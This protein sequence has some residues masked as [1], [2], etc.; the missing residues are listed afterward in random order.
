MKLD[1]EFR[2]LIPS[3]T[4][5]EKYQLQESILKEGCRDALVLWKGILIDGHNRHEICRKNKIP[6]KTVSLNLDT[7]AEVK[8]WI[9][10]NQLGRR[11]LTTE[12]RNY[13][14]GKLYSATKQPH[15]GNRKNG[16][17]KSSSPQN[18]DL[19]KTS[20]KI[21][22]QIK[23]GKATVERAEK[24]AQA[25]D[26]LSE[27][28]GEAIKNRILTRD[29]RATQEEILELANLSEKQQKSVLRVVKEKDYPLKDALKEIRDLT[30]YRKREFEVDAALQSLKDNMPS[31]IQI[32]SED[33][34]KR[35]DKFGNMNVSYLSYNQYNT[36]KMSEETY[37]RIKDDVRNRGF[38]DPIIYHC[39]DGEIISG[40]HRVKIARELGKE[41]ELKLK[42]I[43][44]PPLNERVMLAEMFNSRGFPDELK[45]AEIY[46]LLV[47]K[48]VTEGL[49]IEKAKER[50]AVESTYS[51]GMIG[52]YYFIGERI[53]KDHPWFPKEIDGIAVSYLHA[54]YL[55][56]MD[57]TRK[58]Y[59]REM[60]VEEQEHVIRKIIGWLRDEYK[61]NGR[62]VSADRLQ[63]KIR[64]TLITDFGKH[65]PNLTDVPWASVWYP[66]KRVESI[67]H[68]IEEEAELGTYRR[69]WKFSMNRLTRVSAFPMSVAFNLLRLLSREL[70]DGG[71]VREQTFK[72]WV[73]VDPFCGYGIR[74]VAARY[75]GHTAYGYDVSP[76]IM[77]KVKELWSEFADSF[78]VGDSRYLPHED[79]SVDLIFTSPPYW[80]VEKYEESEDNV[81]PEFKKDK[82]KVQSQ[83]SRIN[84]YH[85]FLSELFQVIAE[86]KRVVKVGGYLVIVVANF[87]E[88]G[89]YYPFV[90]AVEQYI[91]DNKFEYFDKLI[92]AHDISKPTGGIKSIEK[93]HTRVAHEEMLIFK[94]GNK[95]S[96]EKVQKQ[97]QRPRSLYLSTP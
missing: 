36:N 68:F 93:N 32:Y 80:R 33:K 60:G 61:V 12:A 70:T 43:G 86:M 54:Y 67:R 79:E 28:H 24:Y 52:R 47:Q 2:A 45:K 38:L 88:K 26:K 95:L 7:R 69:D 39:S 1:S 91:M 81:P 57:K 18:D 19:K 34:V 23:I 89:K 21:A 62:A 77:T 71:E 46:Y 66:E 6:F 65:L 4:S 16:R 92:I 90:H 8:N 64:S 41:S 40:N 83:L 13:L 74:V 75:M 78:F 94:K 30:Y 50:L 9:I 97:N 87:R 27:L 10:L 51:Q 58:T 73:I 42:D 63:A 20:H 17:N 82:I 35:I 22:E 55:L 72:K 53:T 48:Y 96:S 14:I 29:I 56:R 15:G 25:V 3:L 49:P 44:N 37:E 31:S 5:E 84:D 76:K 59:Q 85:T 11:N